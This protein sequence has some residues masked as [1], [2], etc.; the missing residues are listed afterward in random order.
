MHRHDHCDHE[1][2]EGCEHEHGHRALI[3]QE[4]PMDA[5]NQSLSDALR[6][7]FG[8]LKIIMIVLIVLYL[9]SNVRRIES[10]EQALVLRMGQL[11]PT[12]YEAGLVWAFPFPI[13]EIVPLPSKK[14]NEFTVDSHTFARTADEIGKP[15][16]MIARGSG[17]LNPAL[18]GALLTADTGLVHVQWKVFYKIEDL[19][20]YVTQIQCRALEAAEDLI[21][22]AVETTGIHVAME[23]TAEEILR[24]NVDTV[25]SEMMRRVNEHL[26]ALNSGLLVTGIEM[27]DWTPPI[28]VKPA[29]DGTQQAE[30]AKQ[31]RIQDAEQERTKRLN[32]AAGAAHVELVQLLDDLDALDAGKEPPSGSRQTKEELQ[33]RIDTLLLEKVEGKAGRMIR[34]ASSYLSVV[35]SRMQG[36]LELYRTLLPEYRR[37]P[38]LLIE[39]LWQQTRA[40]LLATSEAV[41][42]MRPGQAQIRI[43]IPYDP[44]QARVEE[45]K[46]L[47]KQDFDPS[48]LRPEHW[49]TFGPGYD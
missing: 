39:R 40:E 2:H 8:I 45:T 44:E 20:S 41:K 46:R 37:S 31:R 1:H 14:S 33:A 30:N 27:Y 6:A 32:E 47:E 48:K 24:T 15:L 12:V 17:G 4:E 16:S 21:R 36:D 29:F 28:P 49:K 13:D 38:E 25:K 22:R 26:R 10:H 18:D 9:F 5:A 23:M 34:D 35:V 7:S 19:K 11:Q 43:K 42:V 3:S